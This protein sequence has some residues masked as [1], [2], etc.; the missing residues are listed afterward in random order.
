M[1]FKSPQE[2]I[3][4]YKDLCAKQQTQIEELKRL[5]MLQQEIHSHHIQVSKITQNRIGWI[6][7]GAFRPNEHC[8]NRQK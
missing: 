7:Y 1:S 8:V 2:E 6:V 5:P 4:Y 3:A